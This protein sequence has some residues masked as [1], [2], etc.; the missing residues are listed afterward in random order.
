MRD[1]TEKRDFIR[2]TV[3]C[4]VSFTE[5]G[6]DKVSHGTGKNLSGKG[7]LFISRHEIK[8]GTLLD[9]TVSPEN[10]V[11]PPLSAIVQVVRVEM[12]EPGR[13]YEIGALIQDLKS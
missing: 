11:T 3:D 7:I 9:L 6:S 2:M 10:D 1:Y 8:I 12:L 5:V 4:Q 13:R